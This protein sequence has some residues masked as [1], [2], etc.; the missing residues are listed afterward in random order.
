MKRERAVC[1]VGVET[2][3]R[4]RVGGRAA[5]SNPIS[6]RDWNTDAQGQIAGV[7]LA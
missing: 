5:S 6:R 3:E 4:D 1:L 2:R 7:G